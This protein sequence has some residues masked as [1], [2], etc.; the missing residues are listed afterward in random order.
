MWV[1][2][3]TIKSFFLPCMHS[4]LNHSPLHLPSLPPLPPSVS[5]SSLISNTLHDIPSMLLLPP[6]QD[7]YPEPVRDRPTQEEAVIVIGKY[8]VVVLVPFFICRDPPRLEACGR[9]R[10]WG[11]VKRAAMTVGGHWFHG[12]SRRLLGLRSRAW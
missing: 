1:H 8:V 2:S 3:T 10:H 9:W 6:P 7:S 12:G 11:W 4:T 5:S